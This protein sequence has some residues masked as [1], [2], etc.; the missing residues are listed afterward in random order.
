M[1]TTFRNESIVLPDGST[2]N[3]REMR[4]AR[5]V[6]EYGA[7]L[8]LG[9]MADN[10]EWVVLKPGR[11]SQPV[12]VLGLG[13]ELL[14]PEA[15]KERLYKSDV[16]RHGRKLMDEVVKH[17]DA[18]KAAVAA[19]GREASQ[20]TAEAA[21]HVARKLGAMPRPVYVPDVAKA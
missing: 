8:L 15:I 21:L 9:Q 5:A 11:D 2:R 19:K 3:V 18:V 14:A 17:N 7:D 13:F 16:Q 4:A 10:G 6:S 1:I 20:Q 12:P